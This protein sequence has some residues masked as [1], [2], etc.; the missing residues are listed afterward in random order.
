MAQN[1]IGKIAGIVTLNTRDV[2]KG[3]NDA[4]AQLDAFGNSIQKALGD[5]NRRAGKSFDSIFT[6]VQKLQ[7]ALRALQS[8][9]AALAFPKE[10]ID[11]ANNLAR[12]VES[13]F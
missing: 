2:T 8:Q 10:T 13:L 3:V 12:A 11:R 5:A 1:Y 7:A 9:S 4:K 6:P